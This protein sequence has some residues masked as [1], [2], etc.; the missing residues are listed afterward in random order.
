MYC[1]N[2]G[3]ETSE[4]FCTHCGKLALNNNKE[5]ADKSGNEPSTSRGE[6][7]SFDDYM[8]KKSVDRT[9]NSKFHSKRKRG[10]PRKKDGRLTEETHISIAVLKNVFGTFKVARGT[11]LPVKVGV[12]D[13]SYAVKKAAF[14]KLSR[15][16][17]DFPCHQITDC[18]LAYRSGERVRY[19][20][21]TN[22]P[23]TV[24]SYKEDLGVS[25]NRLT[26]YLL[27]YDDDCDSD[28]EDLFESNSR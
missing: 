8:L 23:F 15:Y 28:A 19:L 9:S 14:D 17:P 27:P 11:I 22:L 25:Y 3:K 21:G 4:K 13:D 16:N 12:N 20:P 26:L 1:G 10:L 6:S 18:K 24:K 7:L 5:S 2:C